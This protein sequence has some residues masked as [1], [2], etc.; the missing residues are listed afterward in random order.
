MNA[1]P[2]ALYAEDV[3]DFLC[4]CRTTIRVPHLRIGVRCSVFNWVMAVK[5]KGG[6][7]VKV[8]NHLQK[9]NLY[10]IVFKLFA[11]MLD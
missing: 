10:W 9:V 4:A 1:K 5:R 8:L 6:V 3:Q 2:M 7:D 11:F